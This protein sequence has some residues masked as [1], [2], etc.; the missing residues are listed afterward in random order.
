MIVVVNW[1]IVMFSATNNMIFILHWI[2]LVSNVF[3]T[4]KCLI[5]LK[6][7]CAFDLHVKL[8]GFAIA[9][10]INI[11]QDNQQKHKIFKNYGQKK[12]EFVQ[13]KG[14]QTLSAICEHQRRRFNKFTHLSGICHRKHNEW[15]FINNNHLCCF[16]VRLFIPPES[17]MNGLTNALK[18]TVRP[19]YNIERIVYKPLDGS[20]R[21]FIF[22][23]YLNASLPVNLVCTFLH[24]SNCFCVLFPYSLPRFFL[25]PQA[26][27]IWN[28]FDAPSIFT[29]FIV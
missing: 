12:E 13:R 4:L 2:R 26:S 8:T 28:P 16:L 29:I 11:E 3:R 25:L 27:S 9:Y 19:I 24:H 14:A 5:R 17:W 20:F 7:K 1:K 18:C 22:N 23:I 10:R 21:L 15:T 6:K